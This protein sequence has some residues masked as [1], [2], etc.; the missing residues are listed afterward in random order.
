M[1][2]KTN[3]ERFTKSSSPERLLL[4]SVWTQKREISCDVHKEINRNSKKKKI[5]KLLP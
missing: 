4:D 2:I 3:N 1:L 5:V